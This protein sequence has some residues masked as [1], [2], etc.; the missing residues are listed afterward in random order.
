MIK[1]SSPSRLKTSLSDYTFAT[2]ALMPNHLEEVLRRC[3]G[4]TF[5]SLIVF[6]I[7]ETQIGSRTTASIDIV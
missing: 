7:K 5:F 6:A 2:N 3:S 1:L 4:M